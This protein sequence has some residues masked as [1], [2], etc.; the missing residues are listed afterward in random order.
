MRKLFTFFALATV[1]AIFLAFNSDFTSDQSQLSD[2]T[3]NNKNKNKTNNNIHVIQNGELPKVVYPHVK[4]PRYAT[5]KEP[6]GSRNNVQS[7][8]S[9]TESFDSTTFP[10]T[11]WTDSLCVGT[12]NWARATVT[13]FPSG[14]APHSGLGMAWYEAYDQPYPG[15]AVLASPPLDFSQRGTQPDSVVFWLFRSTAYVYDDSIEVFV[16]TNRGLTG[17]VEIGNQ[18]VYGGTYTWYRYAY[19]IPA[20][21]TGST[22]YVIFRA[23]SYYYND[24]YL[25]DVTLT[26][27]PGCSSP[28][29]DYPYGYGF[30]TSGTLDP[31]WTA[32][33]VSGNTYNWTVATVEGAPPSLGP[34]Q[35][36]YLCW[37]NSYDATAGYQA[38]LASEPLNFTSLTLP[39]LQFW[40]T[41]DNGEAGYYDSIL[42]EAST[43]S[44]STWTPLYPAFQRYESTN[45][46]YWEQET[47]LLPAYAG[48]SNVEVGFL[49]C[50]A[51]GDAMGLDTILITQGTANM[52]Y[53]S[54]TTVLAPQ[55]VTP[56]NF[57]GIP[58]N[59][60]STTTQG[61]IVQVQVV[62]S[63]SGSPITVTSLSMGTNG[64]TAPATDISGA[65]LYYTGTTNTFAT[66]TVFGT[67]SSP[68]GTFSVS[69]SQALQTGTNYFWLC[70]NTTA[71]A[72][73]EDVL[74][75]QC[76]TVTGNNG[77]G[78]QVPSTTSPSGNRPIHNYYPGTFTTAGGIYAIYI[79][80]VTFG[81]I[82]QSSAFD[83]NTNYPYAYVDYATT[84]GDTQSVQQGG[85]NS[86]SV[87][88]P[89]TTNAQGFAV[90]VDWS[91]DGLFTDAGDYTNLGV[92]PSGGTNTIT[93]NII[94]PVA[95]PLG[96]HRMRV[97]NNFSTAPG[98]GDYGDNLSYGSTDDF[99]IN[100]IAATNMTYASSIVTQNVVTG[101]F[102][103][104]TNLQIIGI[105]VV[106]NGVLNPIN[107]TSFTV[108]DSGSTN[109]ITDLTHAR[110]FYTG[111]SNVF[112]ATT[113]F[114]STVNVTAQNQSLVISGTQPLASGTNYF[115]MAYDVPGSAVT[116]DYVDA[117]CYSLTVGGTPYVPSVTNPAGNRQI[118]GSALCGVYSIPGSYSSIA[119]AITAL[120]AQGISCNVTFNVA[121]GWHEAVSGGNLTL[122]TTGTSSAHIT[123]QKSGSGADP[124]I[125]G[126]YGT[127]I[128][129]AVLK[130]NGVSYVTINGIDVQ[131]STVDNGNSTYC[132]EY[133]Y[134]LARP[135]GTQGCQYDTIENCNVNLNA[136]NINAT[137]GIYSYYANT[138]G[139][140]QTTTAFSG[141]NSNNAFLGNTISNVYMG[142]YLFGYPS[143]SPYNLYDFNNVVSNSSANPSRIT[144]F[145]GTSASTYGYGI[146]SYYQSNPMITNTKLQNTSTATGYIYG[147]YA[148]GTNNTNFT[149]TGDTLLLSCAGTTSYIY[150]IYASYVVAGT[151]N[152]INF[153]NNYMSYNYPS[154][155]TGVI[156][157]IYDA[158]ICGNLIMSGNKIVGTVYG[159]AALSTGTM[160]PYWVSSAGA[161]SEMITNNLDSGNV[162]NGTTCYIPYVFYS[163]VTTQNLTYTGNRIMNNVL[164]GTT[165]TGSVYGVYTGSGTVSAI[166]SNNTISSNTLPT[167]GGSYF[168]NY[169]TAAPGT[170]Y[171]DSNTVS[172]NAMAGTGY[173]YGLEVVSTPFTALNVT[174]NTMIGNNHYGAS[175]TGGIYGVYVST[176]VTGTANIQNNTIKDF[177]SAAATYM[178]PIYCLL[179]ANTTA[180]IS[181]NV[182]DSISTVG[183]VNFYGIYSSSGLYSNIYNNS[184]S[185]LY[186][187]NYTVYGMYIGSGTNVNIYNNR[188][189]DLRSPTATSYN[190]TLYGMYIGGGTYVNL[191]YNTIYLNAT[192]TGTIFGS[193]CLYASTVPTLDMRNN[194][195]VNNSASGSS[196]GFVTA[197]WRSANSLGTQT[198]TSDNNCFYAGT[199]GTYHL[200][201]YD[202]TN[203]ELTLSAYKNWMVPREEASVTELPPFVNV[204][205]P[206]YDLHISTSTPTQLYSTGQVISTSGFPTAP[207]NITT[208]AFGTA[209][210]P[211]AGYPVGSPANNNPC[212]GAHEF[213][214]LYLA[215]AP[216][217]IW[218]TPLGTGVAG[219]NRAFTG[220]KIT[221][222]SGI[223]T[224]SG[225][226][227]RCYYRR[228][229]DGNVINDNT[230]GTDGWKYVQSNGTTT[231]FDFT[232]D[233]TI[234][235]GGTGVTNGTIIDYLVIAQDLA[236]TPNAGWLGATFGVN[237]TT[238]A[239]TASNPPI[240][241]TYTYSIT[242]SSYCGTIT[243]GTS[244]TF[245]TL[246]GAGGLFSALNSGV[247][248]GNI[249]ATI[250]SNI[251]EPGTFSLG[252]MSE[253]A[254]G[255][256]TITIVPATGTLYTLTGSVAAGLLTFSGA[257]R[258]IIDGNGGYPDAPVKN[259]NGNPDLKS[260][261]GVGTKGGESGTD[262]VQTGPS[263]YLLIRNTIGS[264]PAIMF[265]NGCSKITVKNCYIES[266]N[267]TGYSSTLAGTVS[268]G[269]GTTTTGNDT[270]SLDYDDIRD[271]SDAAGT[272]A[273]GVNSFGTSTSIATY[274]VYDSINNCNIYNFYYDGGTVESGISIY[275]YSSHWYIYNNSFYQ[276]ATRTPTLL[277][278]IF[279]VSDEL[280]T[281]NDLNLVGNY[282]GGTAPQ[283]GGTA[284][285]YNG[286][287]TSVFR[288]LQL[289][290]GLLQP[291]SMEGNTIQ[292]I[293][294]STTTS[295]GIAFMGLY[296]QTGWINVG[297]V[298]GNTIGSGTGNGNITLN[299]GSTGTVCSV[300]P[301]YHLGIGAINNN[302]I[303]SITWNDGSLANA[304]NYFYG[305]V[306]S[307]AS[308]T[309][310][311]IN[312]NLIGSTT[313]SNSIQMNN[314]LAGQIIYPIYMLQGGGA[315]VSCTNNT[316]AN[317]TSY[318]TT[319]T[320]YSQMIGIITSA[321]AANFNINSNS[322]YN[323]TLNTNYYAAGGYLQGIRNTGT[324]INNF[325]NNTIY[326][327]YANAGGAG[328][329]GAISVVGLV[330]GGT[331]GGT[332]SGNKIYDLRELSTG[333]PTSGQAPAL[334]GFNIQGNAPYNLVNNMVSLTNG[335]AS[336]YDRFA[337][338]P[339]EENSVKVNSTL[340]EPVKTMQTL[341]NGLK[342]SGITTGSA[343]DKINNVLLPPPSESATTSAFDERTANMKGS[344]NLKPNRNNSNNIPKA[345]VNSG[346]NVNSLYGIYIYGDFHTST[347]NVPCNFYYN[348]WYVGGT[349]PSASTVG[350]WTFYRYPNQGFV[351]MRD[352]LFVNNRTGGTGVYHY[353]I[354]N[355]GSPPASGWLSTACNY[356]VYLGSSSSSIGEWGVGVPQTFSQWQSSMGGD[357]QSWSTT[358]SVISP[359]NLF[360]NVSTGNLQIQSANM[361]AWLVS[362]KG[363]ALSGY[364]T[365]YYG[366]SR[367]TTITGGCTSI[368]A[369]QVA[370]AVGV[371]PASGFDNAPG[372]GVTSNYTQWGRLLAT[373]TW[374][375]G[376]TSYPS[377]IALHYYSG[378]NPSNV[379][380]G[381]YSNS[382]MLLT[383]TGNLTGTS[384]NIQ[385]WFGDNET[386]TISSPNSNTIA[387]E[388]VGPLWF[389][390]PAGGNTARTSQ[391]S[392]NSGAESYYVT[393]DSIGGFNDFA[394]TDLTSALPVT[395]S[396]FSGASSERD[397]T[398][399]WTTSREMNNA[400][401][402]IERRTVVNAGTST[403]S[404]W[405]EVGSLHG[406]G[407]STQPESYSYTDTK[408]NVGTY[409]YR[410]KQMD[411]NG[412]AEYF[413]LTNPQNVVIGKPGI[414]MVSQNYPNPSNPKSKIDYQIP[415]DGRVTI[416]VYDL[417]G[418]EVV[419]LYDG[420]QTA[421]YYTTEFDGTNVASGVYIYRIIAE[422]DNQKF[423][424]SKK[425]VLLK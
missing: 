62:T 414:A 1:G 402:N 293:N 357:M 323:L 46:G 366:N 103:P 408:M 226:R 312:N 215:T 73:A 230:S 425:M 262:N 80:N 50:S 240:N 375:T 220:V 337:N 122:N 67:V 134:M 342:Y 198:Q 315:T 302:T 181:G 278:T 186:E 364:G 265:Q 152:T 216:P 301:I 90:Y 420:N 192:T 37:Y 227:P 94:V 161:L 421:G 163:S 409:Q 384:Y 223:N 336:N 182:V 140:T 348:S 285:T 149:F 10:P 385:Y 246:T 178:Y 196:S 18:I 380:G 28:I 64:S 330:G 88:C 136:T 82:N 43:N 329:T 382:N 373:V 135:S 119:A 101:F 307:N 347:S 398:L 183:I 169:I 217:F 42:V 31:C 321:G 117:S 54:S 199:P 139:V 287:S 378:V 59:T 231:P 299:T 150:G 72:V 356:D 335:D 173:L 190:P 376:G 238:V 69:G 249:T 374:G 26:S 303:G 202:G 106:T 116:N 96:K 185:R 291:S 44:G 145:G 286:T 423:T 53:V 211:N 56:N 168:Y 109:A 13:A 405:G 107:A 247:V 363:I 32:S 85:T 92:L 295:G 391:L 228:S 362:G 305:I 417:A 318:S 205:S 195:F 203:S 349:Q 370:A 369:H 324:G 121:A 387:A 308:T 320:Y 184:I 120:N 263:K 327:L 14:Y 259:G 137:Y 413:N 57:N 371:N 388:Y 166:F 403:Y 394:L 306:Y 344:R 418:K 162:M 233:Y 176:S 258:I 355:E 361:E 294:F 415:F 126:Y 316:I 201:F 276:T 65:T 165:A 194:V 251:T 372:S 381:H 156:E 179:G 400:G 393:I 292:N 282:V 389:V 33:I 343:A 112:A 360:T 83:P 147:L 52:T 392:W 243:V 367:S 213:G 167:T 410:L 207:I 352:N 397:I 143:A 328:G 210:Y 81:N 297:D 155:T 111:T 214:G 45:A 60:S 325:N 123:F 175:G 218:Y 75:A 377:S 289:Y 383:N 341:P 351:Y 4:D 209:R 49:A 2:T 197:Y 172:Y 11:G 412:D 78:T 157:G 84:T 331:T 419:T 38:L 8:V 130:L 7:A 20:S 350:S 191:Y 187:T 407:N 229:T 141:T 422:G 108:T 319:A 270:I 225:T 255:G 224:T 41:R 113:Q 55:P 338:L 275:G 236:G 256:Y 304:Y 279:A 47:K 281:C 242:S 322:V 40:M 219:N 359:T 79:S 333:A 200:I 19:A 406:H 146:Y 15:Y 160:Y 379:V 115:W 97:R 252:T 395:M 170:L 22:N 159:T 174:N 339:N 148:Y 222:V 424:A 105:Q 239:L 241:S 132:M 250:T 390:F 129:D 353:V 138:T 212:M 66:T 74:H 334:F 89:N 70:Y 27:F 284:M 254:P 235:N 340:K 300:Y 118:L 248:C 326:S 274:N 133:G 288:A 98:S 180:N 257:H 346:D 128:Y 309:T 232:I 277:N 30:G 234:L 244:G 93:G 5:L 9:Y 317:I 87:S 23:C 311:T 77:M 71:G 365:D 271:R 76:N 290:V 35:G 310:F 21:F 386:Y 260:K 399:N 416:K 269:L 61:Q 298:T 171:V 401:F 16:N 154:A 25:D 58:V 100:V 17:A 221:S 368:G 68:N 245:P 296:A 36:P 266:N 272:P 268:F 314:L 34:Y 164:C 12:I 206:P 29:S 261:T 99:W 264:Y 86:I 127:G 142:Y 6:I 237:P 151:T 48:M 95:A 24:I 104:Q 273:I 153:S 396:S 404:A 358:T 189:S 411:Y 124:V 102:A 39:Q 125:T 3:H 51:Y 253:V 345:P 110:L 158:S 267:I 204:A 354:G 283:C 332:I 188:I 313:T 208:D 193:T 131:D 114:G 177:S 63:G 91:N 280:T 144:N